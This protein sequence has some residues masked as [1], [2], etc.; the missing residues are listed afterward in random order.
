ML[1]L[2]VLLDRRRVA[3]R[4]ASADVRSV[5]EALRTRQAGLGLGGSGG[6]AECL[7][8]GRAER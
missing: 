7:S 1:G 2:D 4:G 3:A 5:D 6:L 8:R